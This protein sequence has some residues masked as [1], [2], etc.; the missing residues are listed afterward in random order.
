MTNTS[1]TT[2]DTPQTNPAS[3]SSALAVLARH[4]LIA[5]AAAGAIALSASAAGAANIAPLTV[6][7]WKGGAYSNNTTGA[8]SHC[9]AS[10]KYKSG[11]ALLFSVTRKGRWSMGLAS[12]EW[13]MQPGQVYPVRFQVDD[14]PIMN[15]KALAKNQKLVQI[16]LPSNSKIF[17]H[18]RYG[19]QLKVK[20]AQKL[21]R[22][23]LTGAD[24]ML[25]KL[26]QCVTHYRNSGASSSPF[27]APVNTLD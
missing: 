11:I 5:L 9:A 24:P 20:A 16:S 13:N 6:G 4:G 3:R 23:N 1:H 27:A 26:V 18:F 7:A 2:T 21:I 19:G 25:K 15:G 12:N 8:F 14:G 10:A 17:S 22:F